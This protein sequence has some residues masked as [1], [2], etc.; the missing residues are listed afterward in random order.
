MICFDL[1]VFRVGHQQTH[2]SFNVSVSD[3][4]AEN[5]SRDQKLFILNSTILDLEERLTQ[6]LEKCYSEI[7]NLNT[8]ILVQNLRVELELSSL[9]ETLAADKNEISDIIAEETGR[10]S[11]NLS[12]SLTHLQSRI[13][14]LRHNISHFNNN[15][16]SMN[17]SLS[18][19]SEKNSIHHRGLNLT[20]ALHAAAILQLDADIA[21]LTN[22]SYSKVELDNHSLTFNQSLQT[23]VNDIE[24]TFERIS[25]DQNELSKK[26]S[27]LIGDHRLDVDNLNASISSSKLQALDGLNQLRGRLSQIELTTILSAGYTPSHSRAQHTY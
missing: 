5:H 2:S 18:L 14:D 25:S 20:L 6:K 1:F 26:L 8:G 3:L 17:E 4:Y 11:E 9:N 27:E 23:A 15:V 7:H 21:Q 22:I 12:A 10:V 24:V 13:S 19:A 16:L